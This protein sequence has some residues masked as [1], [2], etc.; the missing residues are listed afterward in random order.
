MESERWRG[1]EGLVYLQL[2]GHSNLLSL[3]KPLSSRENFAPQ[4]TFG[5]TRDIFNSNNEG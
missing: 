2:P 3:N 4:R 1:S 5:N